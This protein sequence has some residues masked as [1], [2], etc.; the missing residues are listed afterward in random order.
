MY[1]LLTRKSHTDLKDKIYFASDFHLGSPNKDESL[2]REKR[3]VSWLNSI[4]PEMKELYLLGDVFDFWFEY[5][6]V[7]PKGYSRLIGKLA[8]LSDNG[9]SITLFTGNHDMWM[10]DYFKEELNAVVYRDPQIFIIDNKR[11]Y[12]AHGDGLGP[13][14]K[15]FK[16]L[17][18]IFTSPVSNWLYAR[19]H[20]DTGISVANYFSGKSRISTGSTDAVFL[21]MENEWL[22]QHAYRVLQNTEIDYFIFGHRHLPL[23]IQLNERSKY[24]NTGDWLNYYTYAVWDGKELKLESFSGS[25]ISSP[26]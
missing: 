22:V 11:F 20:P 13:G 23:D 8:E 15:G 10:K 18:K 17:K 21:G 4:E 16:V 3:I 14:D 1:F 24:I 25:P 2:K 6:N 5:R 26:A 12:L 19:I 9:V 7:I